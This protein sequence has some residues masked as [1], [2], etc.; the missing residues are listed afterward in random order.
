MF[1]KSLAAAALSCLLVPAITFAANS[2]KIGYTWK[3]DVSAYP[4]VLQ[5]HWYVGAGLMT[6]SS[7]HNHTDTSS[8]N[9]YITYEK[10]N[11]GFHLYTGYQSN[12]HW[13]VEMGYF[14]PGQINQT[15]DANTENAKF[16][17]SLDI[18]TLN[19]IYMQPVLS[20][21]FNVYGKVGYGYAWVSETKKGDDKKDTTQSSDLTAGAG[22]QYNIPISTTQSISIRTEALLLTSSYFNIGSPGGDFPLDFTASLAYNF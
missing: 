13:G 2:E 16:T 18:L 15:G 20:S 17:E 1:K 22:I 12:T 4:N 7:Y 6:P 11:V 3:P 5:G 21:N 9:H 14:H 8:S 19:I 10:E